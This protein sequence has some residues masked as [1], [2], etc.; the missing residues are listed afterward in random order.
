MK[1]IKK[2]IIFG[3]IT[4]VAVILFAGT[5]SATEGGSPWNRVWAAIQ[6]LQSQITNIQLIPGPTG[7]QG[8]AG[9]DG[10]QGLQ[11]PAGENINKD[12]IYVVTSD[13]VFVFPGPN[14]FATARCH[15]NNDPLLSGGFI[16]DQGFGK[17]T[18]V[19]SSTGS[20]TDGTAGWTVGA[21]SDAENTLYPG[22][23]RAEA[24]C[25][26]VD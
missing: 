8:P 18:S 2:L 11:G 9:A 12:R 7:A 21:N 16:L 4:L 5:V 19:I 10:V 6:D 15:D 25:L 26:S 14:S 23:I 24:Y 13:T 1:S 22:S 20:P 3:A 17:H